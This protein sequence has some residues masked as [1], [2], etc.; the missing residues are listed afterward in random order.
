MTN[1]IEI[2]KAN[3]VS[4]MQKKIEPLL[5]SAWIKFSYDAIDRAIEAVELSEPFLQPFTDA[6]NAT[7]L[8]VATALQSSNTAIWKAKR[9]T[10]DKPDIKAIQ[11]LVKGQIAW[12]GDHGSSSDIAKEVSERFG[13]L[14]GEGLTR[15]K[16]VAG[17]KA[18][19][20]QYTPEKYA[21]KFGEK[22]YWE[23]YTQ[24]HAVLSSS[25]SDLQRM[26]KTEQYKFWA[27]NNERTCD[28]CGGYHGKIFT[29]GDAIETMD[30]YLSAA[31][32][33]DTE[34]MKTARPFVTDLNSVNPIPPLHIGCRCRILPLGT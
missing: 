7:G 17:L 23:L 3:E 18:E 19:F 33:G 4:R 15:N 20:S 30:K 2:I 32:D 14:W 10:L 26:R 16:I 31:K 5:H 1:L 29:T 13:A 6:A 11:N 25:F 28:I 34:G 9:K 22:K 8:S 21:A 27:R 24:H 12:I